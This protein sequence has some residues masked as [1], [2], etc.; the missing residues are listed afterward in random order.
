MKYIET[1]NICI[2]IID[3]GIVLRA[4][5]VVKTLPASAADVRDV[6]S[7]PGLG[8][9][10]GG[11]HVSPLQFSCWRIPWTA[12]PGGL[13]SIEFQR[14]GSNWSSLACIV[15]KGCTCYML[16]NLLSNSWDRHWTLDTIFNTKE[17]LR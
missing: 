10:P 14:V 13:R 8:K 15:F 11:G 16:F 12:E 4:S 3:I 5:Q 7:I 6:G 9:S 17:K 2:L 1:T